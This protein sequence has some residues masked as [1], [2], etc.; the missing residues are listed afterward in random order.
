MS[1]RE[2]AIEDRPRAGAALALVS[3]ASEEPAVP[4]RAREA[5][6]RADLAKVYRQA[7]DL[8]ITH[9]LFRL[10]RYAELE[11]VRQLT[12]SNL[13]RIERFADGAIRILEHDLAHD[14]WVEV[15]DLA[16]WPEVPF[17]PVRETR[18]LDWWREIARKAIWKALNAAGYAE[19]PQHRRLV[20]RWV[21]V[22]GSPFPVPAPGQLEMSPARMAYRLLERY[23]GKQ[24]KVKGKT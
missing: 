5:F 17:F 10:V 22:K 1:L 24:M 4:R 19:L 11:G 9:K 13:W 7:K 14:A 20:T 21:E 2:A 16:G 12:I 3:S 23:I 6:G 15:E 18:T 8:I